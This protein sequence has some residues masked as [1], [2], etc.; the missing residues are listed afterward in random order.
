M[1]PVTETKA[2]L[3][4]IVTGGGRGIGRSITLRLAQDMPVVVVGRNR[5]DPRGPARSLALEYGNGGLTLV[6][7]CPGFVESEMTSRTIR[8]VM[9]RHNLSEAEAQQRVA[10]RCPAKRILPAEEIAETVALIGA[11]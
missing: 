2:R 4:A 3:A 7:P 5:D 9:R 11:G 1:T 6:A 8:G 10:A